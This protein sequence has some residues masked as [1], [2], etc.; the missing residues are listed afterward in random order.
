MFASQ[1][2]YIKKMKICQACIEYNTTLKQCKV[3]KCIMPIKNRL[4]KDTCPLGKH[5]LSRL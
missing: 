1:S 5:D 3:C 4:D 2:D